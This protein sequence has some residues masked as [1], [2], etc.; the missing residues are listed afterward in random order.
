MRQIHLWPEESIASNNLTTVSI[1]IETPNQQRTRL[2]YRIP[3]EYSQL[4][5]KSSDPFVVATIF[6]A[7]KHSANL[8]VHGQ[9]SP[10]LLQNLAEFQAAWHCWH[11]QH[12][13][14]VEITGEIEQEL[15]KTITEERAISTFSGGVDSCFTAFR[16]RTGSCGR[17]QRNLSAGLMVHGFDI[18]L[19]Q[20]QIFDRAVEKSKAILASL[21]MELIPMATNFRELKLDWEDAFGA[22]AASCLMLLQNGYTTGLICG[23][24]VYSALLLPYGSNPIT[25]PLLA[26][27]S[28]AILHDGAGFTRLEKI[29]EIGKWPEA[30]QNLRVCWEGDLQ[31]RNCGHCEK[32]VRTILGFRVMG[33]SLPPSFEQD[34]TDSQIL[35]LKGVQED[36]LTELEPILE[37]AK[38]AG[39]SDS[40]VNALAKSIARNRQTAKMQA[41][42]A[43]LKKLL[44]DPLRHLWQQLHRRK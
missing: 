17:L 15:E 19:S 34:V 10:S 4:L 16:H 9:V 23:S 22:A 11:P 29:K 42:L 20:Q 2:W 37:A 44:P 1:T 31:D 27:K 40:W 39:I 24:A 43:T 38:A 5:T 26:S 7:M 28:F 6:L 32:C 36:Q 25:D 30:L 41:Y 8:I 12:Y 3:S 13:Q 14:Q 33:I 35:A 21:G 18:P